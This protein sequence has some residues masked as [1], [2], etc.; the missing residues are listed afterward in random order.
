[1][2]WIVNDRPYQATPEI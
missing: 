2:F 1:M